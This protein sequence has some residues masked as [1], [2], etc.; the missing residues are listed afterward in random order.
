LFKIDGFQQSRADD[1]LANTKVSLTAF[2]R[3]MESEDDQTFLMA[4]DAIAPVLHSDGTLAAAV[5]LAAMLDDML[6]FNVY[7]TAYVLTEEPR[8]EPPPAPHRPVRDRL[9]TFV[10]AAQ[11][12]PSSPLRWEPRPPRV[13]P[14]T[15]P[16]R[17]RG[18]GSKPPPCS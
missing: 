7:V 15:P 6:L 18:I 13:T 16:V 14:P 2:L 9:T 17:R 12:E 4:V 8:P 11:V 3:H 5:D 10:R 1:Y